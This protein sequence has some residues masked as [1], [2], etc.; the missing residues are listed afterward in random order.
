[1]NKREEEVIELKTLLHEAKEFLEFLEREIELYNIDKYL[2]ES[3][4][5]WR[6]GKQLNGF[7]PIRKRF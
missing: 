6:I 7:V 3:D 5:A 4:L 2:E 1:M